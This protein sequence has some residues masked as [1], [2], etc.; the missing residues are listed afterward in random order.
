MDTHE[1]L[2]FEIEGNHYDASEA[3]LFRLMLT[4]EDIGNLA[5]VAVGELENVCFRI[6][7][8]D[9][10]QYKLFFKKKIRVKK[11]GALLSKIKQFLIEGENWPL[12]REKSA[13]YK[14]MQEA[15]QNAY[16]CIPIIN[17]WDDLLDFISKLN[18][19]LDKMNHNETPSYQ[20]ALLCKEFCSLIVNRRENARFY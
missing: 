15:A 1:N 9:S 12:S 5:R 11:F 8:K 13:S 20:E 19:I 6:L 3:E 4:R 18:D 16:F 14:F 7:Q 17:S 10:D 2:L